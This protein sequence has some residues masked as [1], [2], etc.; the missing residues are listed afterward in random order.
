ME[1]NPACEQWSTLDWERNCKIVGHVK[2]NIAIT[3][4]V[5]IAGLLVTLFKH[6][7]IAMF[8]MLYQERTDCEGGW[9]AD[10]MGLGK[11]RTTVFSPQTSSCLLNSQR[12]TYTAL[13][14]CYFSMF[15][16][17][18]WESIFQAWAENSPTADQHCKPSTKEYRQPIDSV[19]P[20]QSIWDFPCPCV[21]SSPTHPLTPKL[22]PVLLIIPGGLVPQWIDKIH[23]LFGS[24][25]GKYKVKIVLFWN[26]APASLSQYLYDEDRDQNDIFIDN[27]FEPRYGQTSV[28]VIT[29][30]HSCCG[31]LGA[32]AVKKWSVPTGKKG[33]G[34]KQLQQYGICHSYVIM[35]EA[36]N[37]KNWHTKIFMFIHGLNDLCRHW[38]DNRPYKWFLSGTPLRNSPEDFA[39]TMY[40][41]ER[42]S[43][44]EETSDYY[45]CR[46]PSMLAWGKAF[47][48][49][50]NAEEKEQT[51]ATIAAK[52][53]SLVDAELHFGIQLPKFLIRRTESSR[54]FG[55]HLIQLPTIQYRCINCKTNKTLLK[56]INSVRDDIVRG[57]E[58]ERK[59]KEQ[60]T[61]ERGVSDGQV[62]VSD[63]KVLSM[64]YRLR[65]L[66]TL[67]AMVSLVRKR[68]MNLTLREAIHNGWW[69]NDKT[70]P[71][72]SLVN[73]VCRESDKVHLIR[74][75]L[76]DPT[77]VPSEDKLVVV[78]D[79]AVVGELLA[80]VSTTPCLRQCS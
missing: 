40:C 11:A 4:M 5:T 10:D 33:M 24:D 51:S 37:I 42:P 60:L 32:K 8:W 80:L 66:A 56:E 15:L 31:V 71:W 57:L 17:R 55:N 38:A 77:M 16:D 13:A 45:R 21:E 19:C 68:G 50:L 64:I 6:Q 9:L 61:I 2:E 26:Q 48:T 67:P 20:S 73:D 36:H 43:W 22:G 46:M 70:S 75:L 53:A 63:K 23:Q 54:L 49:Y 28:F 27:E 3:D 72:R 59:E 18:V 76:T 1:N 52:R 30:P 58:K 25:G 35:D 39:G 14:L 74:R 44:S 78:T 47:T 65:V 34:R 12:Q 79:F 41:L 62:F 69:L 7:M 29:T